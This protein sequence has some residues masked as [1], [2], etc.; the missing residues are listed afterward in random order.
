MVIRFSQGNL[1]HLQQ[2][3][4]NS[5]VHWHNDLET[6]IAKMLSLMPQETAL[7]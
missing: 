3:Y 4:D 1:D 7:A 6:A 5:L 2:M